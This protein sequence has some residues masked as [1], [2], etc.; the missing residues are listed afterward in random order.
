VVN[1]LPGTA[2]L[3]VSAK[4]ETRVASSGPKIVISRPRLLTDN[5]AETPHERPEASVKR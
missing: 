2:A 1:R 5:A 3:W 4:G